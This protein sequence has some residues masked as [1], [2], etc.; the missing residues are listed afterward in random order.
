MGQPLTN[1]E[2]LR[3]IQQTFHLSS[4]SIVDI[5]SAAD[6]S[7]ASTQV[8]TWLES[9][10]ATLLDVEL[11]SFL[12]GLINTKRGRKEGELPAAE[13]ELTNNMILM[14]L[15]IA[16]NM[17]SEDMLNTFEKVGCELSK[18]ELGALFRK[19]DNKHYRECTDTMLT[20]FLLALR[21]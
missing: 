12:N 8:E 6:Q 4:V 20:N 10:K 1:N 3:Q 5:F 18:H 15:R 9:T 2:I 7:V 17:K 16:L 21:S 19:P 13:T 14:K 11:A